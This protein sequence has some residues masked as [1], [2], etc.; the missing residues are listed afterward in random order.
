MDASRRGGGRRGASLVDA[1][2]RG[3]VLRSLTNSQ[4]AAPSAAACESARP[5]SG[6]KRT[7][8]VLCDTHASRA[9]LRRASDDDGTQGAGT[10]NLPP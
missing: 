5:L 7:S 10:R 8:D 2:V 6:T 1:A 9:V 3:R 4:P